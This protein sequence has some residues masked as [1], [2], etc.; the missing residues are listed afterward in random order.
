[1]RTLCVVAALGCL[2]ALGGG[3]TAATGTYTA[4]Y[5]GPKVF[6]PAECAPV[7]NNVAVAKPMCLGL[8]GSESSITV[9]FSDRLGRILAGDYTFSKGAGPLAVLTPSNF[10]TSGSVCSGG[11]LTIP[12]GAT[13]FAIGPAGQVDLTNNNACGA[14]AGNPSEGIMTVVMS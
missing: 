11:S 6:G 13:E 9:T 5:V 3:V 7:E 1:M 10:L 8:D 2:G 12:A 4:T 14:A